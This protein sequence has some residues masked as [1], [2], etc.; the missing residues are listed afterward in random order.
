VPTQFTL[1]IYYESGV[2]RA[3]ADMAADGMQSLLTELRLDPPIT[4]SIDVLPAT[5]VERTNLPYHVAS[6]PGRQTMLLTNEPIGAQ[7]W[8]WPGHCVVNVPLMMDKIR[9]RGNAA[10][11][12]VHEWIHTIHNA[13][14]NG[15]VVPFADDAEKSGFVGTMGPDGELRW[16]PWFRHCLGSDPATP[17]SGKTVRSGC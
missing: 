17:E 13:T 14:I 1:E 9:R 10:D 2:D 5:H 3:T 8:G 7:G 4:L 6:R 11:I 15:R 12:L 16:L